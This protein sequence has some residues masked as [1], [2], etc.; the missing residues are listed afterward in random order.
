MAAQP[1]HVEHGDGEHFITLHPRN[2]RELQL[3]A[4]FVTSLAASGL[5][6]N[7]LF[8]SSLQ[9]GP[10]L[11][12]G[13]MTK[14]FFHATSPQGIKASVSRITVSVGRH[15]GKESLPRP[16][17]GIL[18]ILIQLFELHSIFLLRAGQAISVSSV[19][20]CLKKNS[21][22]EM[23]CLVALGIGGAMD[24]LKKG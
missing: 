6:A 4:F 12:K 3:L 11:S 2:I 14:H 17:A 8:R 23:S 16:L 5:T 1:S 24:G 18:T 9:P 20:L 22:A 21:N 13:E 19:L 15:V 7:S 10:R